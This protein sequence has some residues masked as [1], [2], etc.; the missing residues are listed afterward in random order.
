[1]FGVYVGPF[2][3]QL[4]EVSLKSTERSKFCKCLSD[5]EIVLCLDEISKYVMVSFALPSVC[6]KLLCRYW[7]H[8]DVLYVI[9]CVC[10][11]VLSK[12][13][14]LLPCCIVCRAV[15]PMSVCPSVCLSVKCVN[16]DKTKAPSKKSSIMTNRKSTTSFPM[17]LRWTAY[18]APKPPKGAQK[19]KLTI[20]FVSK[21]TSLE[22][23]L[24][25]SFCMW[26]LSRAKW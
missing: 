3:K 16:C 2:E 18:V 10:R 6:R 26:K 15:F 25:Q 21:C 19:R 13:L 17:S 14:H 22:E 12:L 4:T 9:C 24:L 7:I 11:Y 5:C 23:S 8:C 1:M 20:F